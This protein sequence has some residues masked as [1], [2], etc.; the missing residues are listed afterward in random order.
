[1][2]PPRSAHDRL[3]VAIVSTPRSGNTWVREALGR[4]YDVKHLARHIMRDADWRE[5]PHECLLQIHW[6]REPQFVQQLQ[7]N[8]FRVLV[9]ARHPFDVLLS[10]LH[11]VI[12]DVD[13]ERWLDGRGGDER[14]LWGAMPRSRSFID[15][16]KSPRAAELL[17]VSCDWWDDPAAIRVRYEEMVANPEAQWERLVSLLGPPRG[18]SFAEVLAE[19]SLD[20]QR[21]YSINNHFWKGQPGLW[22]LL[23]PPAEAEEIYGSL[24]WCF[25]VLGYHCD[26][27]ANLDAGSAD[28][29]WVQFAGEE[30]G[31]TLRNNSAGLRNVL[32]HMNA[33]CEHVNA[34]AAADRRDRDHFRDEFQRLETHLAQFEG[35]TGFSLHVARVVQRLQ[36]L[37]SRLRRSLKRP[38]RRSA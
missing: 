28:A 38:I 4:I 7:E 13:S 17:A 35:L 2:S 21:R 27:D 11:V 33:H 23:L 1:M 8:G 36:A 34:Q 22:R 18:H 32:D 14:C 19:T 26:P 24:R 37:T 12:Y 6:R 9:V 30:L 16:A 31:R 20:R 29:N 10:I 5:L 15:Y 3:R 25:D